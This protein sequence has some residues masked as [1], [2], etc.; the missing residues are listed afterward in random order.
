MK[1][2]VDQFLQLSKSKLH[3]LPP[4]L[5]SKNDVCLLTY[6]ELKDIRNAIR[7]NDGHV[8]DA[9]ALQKWLLTR[10]HDQRYVIPG[11]QIH[12]LESYSW[13]L[14]C[15]YVVYEFS[16]KV[17]KHL[18]IWLCN[19]AFLISQVYQKTC[20][21]TFQKKATRS[22]EV[23]TVSN[24]AYLPNTI[25]HSRCKIPSRNS[26]FHAFSSIKN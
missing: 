14:F 23:Q 9:H 21:Q 12:T 22:V 15:M 7:T 20:I 25:R 2:D 11:L 26:A 16:T 5:E 3:F 19:C 8:Y 10:S 6:S 17:F 18:F 4:C 13:T 1:I 24:Y